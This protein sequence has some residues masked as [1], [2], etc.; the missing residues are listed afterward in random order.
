MIRPG[1]I[2]ERDE[3]ATPRRSP[4]T[5]SK[6]VLPGIVHYCSDLKELRASFGS[7][8]EET[9]ITLHRLFPALDLSAPAFAVAGMAGV[10]GEATGA[11]MAA[12]VMIFEMTLDY[13][14]I[15][16]MTLTVAISY[17][18]R[19]SLMKDSIYTRK[20][21]LR[22]A[23]VPETMRADISLTV[24]AESIMNRHVEILPATTRLRDLSLPLAD[25]I[26]ALL[27]SSENGALAGVV[28]AASLTH[29]AAPG[30]EVLLADVA[31]TN[32]VMVAPGD[33]LWDVVAAIRMAN[34][35]FA[36]VAQDNAH[37][38]AADVRGIIKCKD[39]VDALASGMELF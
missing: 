15:I 6:G 35:D 5:V 25:G 29:I 27:V 31:Q 2:L 4:V 8:C 38:S 37:P 14:I 17:A 20:L 9:S 19:K 23:P 39:I 26:I 3:L 12:I 22:G 10:V 21:T 32:Y 34:C 1:R 28:T 7:R 13:T 18:V 36:L 24:R 11:A 33:T 16:P 30:P